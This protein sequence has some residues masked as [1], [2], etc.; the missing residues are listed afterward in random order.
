M[1]HRPAPGT[2]FVFRWRKWDGGVHWT[3]ECAYLGEDEH[4]D[5]FGQRPGQRSE[6]PGREVIADHPCVMLLPPGGDW[7]LT[8]N[9][10]PHPTR[11]YIDI[12]WDAAWDGESDPTAIDMDLDVVDDLRYGVWIDDRDEWDEHRVAYGYPA[13]IVARLDQVATDLE[14]E[15]AAHRA[16]FDEATADRWL[17]V[18]ERVAPPRLVG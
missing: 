11:V 15:V 10:L 3:H 12:A 17:G 4:G 7:V 6:R 18:L 9:A 16:P 8:M 14:P 5:W 1:Q 2:P 13:E